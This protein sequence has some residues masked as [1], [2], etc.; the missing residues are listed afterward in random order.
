VVRRRSSLVG[1]GGLVSLSLGVGW[2]ALVLH[3]GDVA[4]VG[5]G[6]G[7]GNDLGTAVGKSDPVGASGGITV[8]A[9]VGGEAGARVVISDGIAVL[10]DSGG[11]ISLLV[12]GSGLVGGLVG[13]GR[14]V[15][16]GGRGGLVSRGRGVVGRGMDRGRVDGGG[17]VGRGMDRGVVDGGGVVSGG[18]PVVSGGRLVGRGSVV[19]GGMGVVAMNGLV[20][21]GGHGGD[22]AGL[23]LLLIVV[24]VHLAGLGRGLAVHGSG[25]GT[26]GLG[27]GGGHSGGIAKLNS[28]V[29]HLVG[30]SQRQDGEDSDKSLKVQIINIK[31]HVIEQNGIL[32]LFTT[33]SLPLIHE[34][35]CCNKST[36]N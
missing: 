36:E 3:I 16:S 14:G 35:Q 2:V 26:V 34:I 23:V 28:L 19:D 1:R 20:G 32:A 12:V 7:V 22:V 33:S 5:I 6:D 21:I 24:L 9:F 17:V 8:T 29:V 11:I 4:A 31:A 10:V 18:G 15:V 27:D 25:M 30:G 13:R